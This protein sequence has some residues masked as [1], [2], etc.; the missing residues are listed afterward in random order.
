[1]VSCQK[2]ISY[3]LIF[4]IINDIVG[5]GV[6]TIPNDMYVHIQHAHSLLHP[7]K[8]CPGQYWYSAM[9]NSIIVPSLK[10]QLL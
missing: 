6:C 10:I 9:S 7:S 1:M 8:W 4:V 3:S 5:Y 2:K